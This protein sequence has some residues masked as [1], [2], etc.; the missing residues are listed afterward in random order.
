MWITTETG[1]L[2]HLDTGIE[3]CVTVLEPQSD[4]VAEDE[5][6]LVVM[7]NPLRP[8]IVHTLARGSNLRIMRLLALL[9]AIL[10]QRA[11]LIDLGDEFRRASDEHRK[12][13]DAS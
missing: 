2:L 8:K 3:I 6:A 5:V 4:E 13:G 9:K 1:S 10:R 12:G 7:K 11:M